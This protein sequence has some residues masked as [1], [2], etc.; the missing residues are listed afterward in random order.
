MIR[1]EEMRELWIDFKAA[2]GKTDGGPAIISGK[3]RAKRKAR[4]L[5]ANKSRKLN[6]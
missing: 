1:N 4:R 3:Q 5:I 2:N 6:R